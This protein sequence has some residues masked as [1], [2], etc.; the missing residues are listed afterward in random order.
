MKAN[1]FLT[2]IRQTGNQTFLKILSG[3]S[4]GLFLCEGQ[5]WGGFR[6]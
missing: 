2:G 4:A 3:G 5:I 1:V 6:S